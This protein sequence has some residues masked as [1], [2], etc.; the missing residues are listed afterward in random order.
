[1]LTSSLKRIVR[2]SAGT[3]LLAGVFLYLVFDMHP[4]NI[5]LRALFPEETEWIYPRA[6]LI[7]LVGEHLLLVAISSVLAVMAGIGSGIFVT[8]RTGRAYLQ[9]I[10]DLTSLAQ[11]FPPVAILA[12]AVPFIGFGFKPTVAALFLYSI[13]PVVRNTISGIE[14]VPTHLIEAASGMGMTRRQILFKVEIPLALKVI[15]AGVRMSVVMNIGTATLGA[16]VGAGGLGVPIISGL[17][18]QNPAFVLEGALTVCLLAVITDRL[19]AGIEDS[20]F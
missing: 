6:M 10:N 12:L 7:E 15:M 13:L 16:I 5:F 20:S 1:M 3:I 9:T 14:A 17:V 8:R 4:W 18:R 2:R 19:I 11:T